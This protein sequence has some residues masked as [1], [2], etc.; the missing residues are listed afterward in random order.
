MR[1]S[2]CIVG[3]ASI[4][5]LIGTGCSG[6]GGG[7]GDSTNPPASGV[8]L[9]TR[10]LPGHTVTVRSETTPVAGTTTTFAVTI[11]PA[12][13]ALSVWLGS[14]YRE[15]AVAVSVVKGSDGVFRISLPVPSTT[16]QGLYVRLTDAEGNH[17]E[18]GNSDFRLP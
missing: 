13:Q 2:I 17:L 4:I 3:L 9:G 18:S 16:T 11:D 8:A 14:E 15:D 1:L 12:P 5:A 6:G 10:T 7:G